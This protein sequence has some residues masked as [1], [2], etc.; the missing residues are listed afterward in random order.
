MS[1]PVVL[2]KQV[3]KCQLQVAQ[4][5]MS[6]HDLQSICFDQHPLYAVINVSLA[7]VDTTP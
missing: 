3:Q 2:T 5:L 6:L 4:Q 7:T 1:G